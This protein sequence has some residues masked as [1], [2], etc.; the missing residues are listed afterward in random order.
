MLF[1]DHVSADQQL[2]VPSLADGVSHGCRSDAQSR[3]AGRSPYWCLTLV[4]AVLTVSHSGCMLVPDI[5]SK[6]QYHNPFPQLSRVAILP[7]R[8]QS[9][10]PT[11]SGSRVSLAYY[12]ELQSI[13]GFEVLPTGLVETQWTA[14]ET[15]VLRRPATTAEDFQRFARYLGVDA[16]LQGA[17]TDYDAY[18]P[19]RMTL[20]VNWYAANPG[21]H[22][23]P[24]GYG[25]PWGTKHE[26][27]IPQ[28][29]RLEAERALARE[30]LKTQAPEDSAGVLEAEEEETE[31]APAAVVAPQPVLP[32]DPF[33]NSNGSTNGSDRD[34]NSPSNSPNPNTPNPSD[35]DS[36]NS[37]PGTLVPPVGSG[38]AEDPNVTTVSATIPRKATETSTRSP[39]LPVGSAKNAPTH[40]NE[41]THWT[42]SGT[43]FGPVRLK[44]IQQTLRPLS[45]SEMQN[46]QATSDG[47]PEVVTSPD[48]VTPEYYN[49]REKLPTPAPSQRSLL[50]PSNIPEATLPLE[51]EALQASQAD[52]KPLLN[53]SELPD[54]W[55][56]PKG[57]I[58]AKPKRNK[59]EMIAQYEPIISHMKAYNGS[60]EDFTESLGEYFYFRD[61]ARFGGWQAYLQRSEDFIRFCCHLHVRETLAARGGELESR[62]ILRWPIGRYQR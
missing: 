60:N 13:P 61:D 59:P 56:D 28:W 11:L 51:T 4:L 43:Q 32:N 31:D 45:A 27:K 53:D 14:F 25:L 30:Q 44:P 40:M 10:E 46:G 12:D 41:P 22:P 8:N 19:P 58:P 24:A 50:F 47:I 39:A 7:F 49:E 21:F 3:R 26:K 6:P 1:A 37:N 48:V 52:A 42:K 36:G 55:P 54:D 5:K 38:V 35:N 20:K 33:L 62:M 16:V 18:Y 9:Q 2:T 57:F 34:P 29:I 15:N 23:I 17:I